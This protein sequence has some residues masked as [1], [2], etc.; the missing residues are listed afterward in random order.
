M[1]LPALHVHTT[2]VYAHPRPVPHRLRVSPNFPPPT[3]RPAGL[4]DIHGSRATGRSEPCPPR[5]VW[6][7][8]HLAPYRMRFRGL[9]CQVGTVAPR[10]RPRLRQFL[11]AAA[12]EYPVPS[13]SVTPAGHGA[14][15]AP[16][17]P[18]AAAASANPLRAAR[19]GTAAANECYRDFTHYPGARSP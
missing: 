15:G 3:G 19:V 17:R 1:F 16:V 9:A 10:W 11:I 6:N 4:G 18:G 8:S 14:N 2:I 5:Q 13:R 12:N 7:P